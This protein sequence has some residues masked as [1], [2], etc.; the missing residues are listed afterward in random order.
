MNDVSF[1]QIL[2]CLFHLDR[3]QNFPYH[4]FVLFLFQLELLFCLQLFFWQ[5]GMEQL[6]LWLDLLQFWESLVICL[7]FIPFRPLQLVFVLLLVLLTLQGLLELV[8][9]R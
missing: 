7:F 8:L 6:Q 2:Q 3:F 5:Q 1:K 4:Q 9:V